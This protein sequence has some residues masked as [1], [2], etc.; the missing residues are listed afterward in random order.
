MFLNPVHHQDKPERGR[1]REEVREEGRE[2]GRERK[3][4]RER[5]SYHY[6]CTLV[7]GLSTSN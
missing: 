7:S 4:G 1:E 2:R 6:S 5:N 3:G